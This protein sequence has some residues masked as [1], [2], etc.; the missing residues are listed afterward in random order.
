MIVEKVKSNIIFQ[1]WK[2]YYNVMINGRNFFN[3]PMKNDLKT[4]D[5]IK[6][7]EGGQGDD[8]TTGCLLNYP[9][10]KKYYKLNKIDLTRHKK[11]YADPKATQQIN[12]TG[13]LSRAEGPTMFFMIDEA[14]ETV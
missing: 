8:Y 13:S 2:K 4:Y 12:F 1:L 14:R 5:N 3:Q 11:L 7:V 6:V 9:Y 10:F